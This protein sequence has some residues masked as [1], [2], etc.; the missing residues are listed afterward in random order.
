MSES[1]RGKPR[2]DPGHASAEEGLAIL[3]GPDGV[4]AELAR[5]QPRS[6]T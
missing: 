2:E 6:D 1:Q 3:D 5:T 4:A